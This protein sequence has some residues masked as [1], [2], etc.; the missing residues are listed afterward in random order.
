MLELVFGPILSFAIT[1]ILLPIIIKIA[2]NR[3][4]VV[5]RQYRKVHI[6]NVSALGGIAIF[7]GVFFSMIF[8]S[9]FIDLKIIKYYIAAGSFIFLFGLRDDFKNSK[10]YEKLL[11]QISAA[12]ILIFLGGL[13]ISQL[14]LFNYIIILPNWASVVLTVFIVI[15][16]INAYNFFDGIDMQAALVALSFLL[17]SGIW[18]YFMGQ[19]N[20]SLLLLSTSA[21]LIAFLY[22]N[23]SPSKIFM[24]DAGTVSI[25]LI[26]A[27]SFLK[28]TNLNQTDDFQDINI[29][30]PFLFGLLAF[31]LPL[32]D[33]IRVIIIRIFKGK[34]PTKADKTHFHHMLLANNWN[35]KEISWISSIYTL[36]TLLINYQIFKYNFNIY[37]IFSFNALAL[38]LLYYST[39][40][41]FKRRNKFKSV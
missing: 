41:K 27:F 29:I 39:F 5:V 33:S 35:H 10:P 1:L 15:W 40:K 25:G 23:N 24:G 16:F 17:P 26:L 32:F 13:K 12:L 38:I 9:D 37:L 31:Q 4:I 11:G 34:N 19:Y 18:F 2:A 28:F 3:N 21:A 6:G 20:F 36:V 7:A 8:F 14:I 30:N 22:Y